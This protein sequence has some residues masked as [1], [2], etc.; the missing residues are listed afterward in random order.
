MVF[1]MSMWSSLFMGAGVGLAGA[2]MAS[3]MPA[4]P[5]HGMASGALMGA[6]A[7]SFGIGAGLQMIE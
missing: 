5:A 3:G 4:N 1:G 6:G 2:G 7:L